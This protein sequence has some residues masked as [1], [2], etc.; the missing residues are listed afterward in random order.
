LVQAMVIDAKGMP[1]TLYTGTPTPVTPA[2][3]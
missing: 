1:M 3:T 2:V